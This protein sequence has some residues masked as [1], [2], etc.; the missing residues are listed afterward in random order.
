MSVCTLKMSVCTLEISV[1]TLKMSRA[2]EGRECCVERRD[3]ADLLGGAEDVSSGTRFTPVT[4]AALGLL[5]VC[6]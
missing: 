1:C 4:D 6:E 3:E 2:S 5:S